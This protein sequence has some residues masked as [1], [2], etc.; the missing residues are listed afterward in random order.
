M[1]VSCGRC[2]RV[3]QTRCWNT[4]ALLLTGAGAWS[5]RTK[6][7]VRARRGCSRRPPLLPESRHVIFPLSASVSE[8]ITPLPIRMPAGLDCDPLWWSLLLTNKAP[9]WGPGD[10]GCST[11]VWEGKRWT[12]K[13]R[14]FILW[15]LLQQ[16]L[17]VLVKSNVSTFPL[18][19]SCDIWEHFPSLSSLTASLKGLTVLCFHLGQWHF[20]SQLL[21]KMWRRVHSSLL[22]YQCCSIWTFSVKISLRPVMVATNFF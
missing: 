17:W 14:L 2:S 15:G 11:W 20:L 5:L 1:Y 7:E 12:L 21:C 19:V 10:S 13:P 22:C 6:C 18:W 3:P 8:S 16:K 9:F 4:E